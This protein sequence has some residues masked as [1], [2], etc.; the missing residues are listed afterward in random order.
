MTAQTLVFDEDRNRF[1]SFLSLYPE[2]MCTIGNLLVSYRDG[3]AWTHDDE[4]N[5]N[6]FFGVQYPS[7]ITLVFN[8]K[9]VAKKKDLAI[10][11]ISGGDKKWYCPEIFT[12]TINEQTKKRQESSLI[13]KDFKLEESVLTASLLRDKNS[14]ADSKKA[15]LQGDY[16][17]GNFISV[18]FEISASNSKDLVSLID[19]YITDIPSGR[20]F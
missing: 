16:L 3:Q 1:E 15:L 12:N 2:M 6:N 20:N 4:P 5:Y 14:M 19:P 13:E 11:Y 10:G 17:G 7:S 9:M 8:D 18:K